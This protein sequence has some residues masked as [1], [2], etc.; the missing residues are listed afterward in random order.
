M[1]AGFH[2]NMEIL[3]D[4]TSRSEDWEC[5]LVVKRRVESGNIVRLV[6]AADKFS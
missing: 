3:I 5:Q 6:E 2:E 4:S 1:R